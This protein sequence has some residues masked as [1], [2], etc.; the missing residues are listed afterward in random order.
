MKANY[1]E[2]RYVVIGEDGSVGFAD[3][4]ED[5]PESKRASAEYME[6]VHYD[7]VYYKVKDGEFDGRLVHEDDRYIF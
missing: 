6:L 1:T 2:W 7:D 3:V 5:I 4:L